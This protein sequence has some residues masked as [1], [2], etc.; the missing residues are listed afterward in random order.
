MTVIIPHST[1]E[2]RLYDFQ[3]DLIS[4]LFEEGRIMYAAFP[5]WIEL[6]DFKLSEKNTIKK[7]Q[8]EEIEFT[9]KSIFC[10]VKIEIEN[11]DGFHI[12]ESKIPLI[13]LNN[14]RAFSDEDRKITMQKKQPVKQ[15]N[16]FR[17][18]IVQEEGPHA[19]SISK[20]VWCKLHHA[21]AT[22]E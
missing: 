10:P 12:A 5:L 18:G 4:S 14:G 3:K 9:E 11:K 21:A 16:V 6:K 8:I 15:L 7:I 19:K 17:L 22:V 20:S 1:E 13:F 2:I